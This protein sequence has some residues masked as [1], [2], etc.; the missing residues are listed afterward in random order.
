MIPSMAP[1]MAKYLPDGSIAKCFMDANESSFPRVF[2]GARL[3]TFSSEII[4]GIAVGTGNGVDVADENGV[5]VGSAAGVGGAVRVK[6]ISEGV[7]SIPAGSMPV[8]PHDEM[9]AE[10]TRRPRN[11]R[12]D[13][14]RGFSKKV[15]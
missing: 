13:L 6:V 9:K 14:K 1:L 12:S 10:N 5:K 2:T 8:E 3:F 15:F 7:V 11:R 4:A